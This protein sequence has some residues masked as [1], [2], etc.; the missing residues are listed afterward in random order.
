MPNESLLFPRQSEPSAKGNLQTLRDDHREAERVVAAGRGQL[1]QECAALLGRELEQRAEGKNQRVVP[2]AYFG[3]LGES[4]SEPSGATGAPQPLRRE[5]LLDRQVQERRMPIAARQQQPGLRKEVVP[6]ADDAG[7]PLLRQ[8]ALPPVSLEDA[9]DLVD[10][11]VGLRRGP[12]LAEP[13]AGV[14]AVRDHAQALARVVAARGIP[15]MQHA[16]HDAVVQLVPVLRQALAL[17]VEQGHR[18]EQQRARRER[19]EP[20]P[21]ADVLQHVPGGRLGRGSIS[22]EHAEPA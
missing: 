6:D 4:A 17:V 19:R 14:H 15:V 11:D 1:A 13:V 21:A 20:V 12:R 18:R 7:E 9:V 16:V 10:T 2:L 22:H 8:E 3:T 5:E